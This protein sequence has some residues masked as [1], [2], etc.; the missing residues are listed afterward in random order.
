MVP[1]YSSFL[2]P[3]VFPFS[4]TADPIDTSSLRKRI[5]DP[6]FS[7]PEQ[8]AKASSAASTR[9][10]ST[11]RQSDRQ[12]FGTVARLSSLDSPPSPSLSL[13]LTERV[14]LSLACRPLEGDRDA[15]VLEVGLKI[16]EGQATAAYHLWRSVLENT[17]Q[18]DAHM[19]RL[20]GGDYHSWKA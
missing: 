20:D 1:Y 16:G 9:P 11:L 3:H 12:P 13:P 17:V 14:D 19:V 5:G 4:L 7:D 8:V 6:C 15:V 18:G 10:A 2:M